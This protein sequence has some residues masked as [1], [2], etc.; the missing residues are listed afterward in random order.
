MAGTACNFA[1]QLQCD[2]H[3][4]GI[5]L[6]GGNA[7]HVLFLGYLK[8]NN[9]VIGYKW[10]YITKYWAF[11]RKHDFQAEDSRFHSSIWFFFLFGVSLYNVSR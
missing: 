3:P 5:F 8:Q 2:I 6:T 9:F 4:L 1:H 10:S 11:V 7:D